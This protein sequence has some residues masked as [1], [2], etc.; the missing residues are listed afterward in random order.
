MVL[1]L[2]YFIII[3]FFCFY[4][5]GRVLIEFLKLQFS[6]LEKIIFSTIL[7]MSSFM[8]F[9]YLFSWINIPQIYLLIL[10]ILNLYFF[11]NNHNFRKIKYPRIDFLSFFII[12]FGS[13]CFSM[14]MFFS[15]FVF[16]DGIKFLVVNIADGIRHI[17]YINNQ[18]NFFPPEHPV[19]SG[20]Q[21]KGFHYF[22]DFMLAKLVEFFR[23]PVLDLYFR[24]FPFFLSLLYGSSFY[25]LAKR[26]T[27]N[28]T[29]H[30]LIVFFSYFATGFS[31]IAFLITGNFRVFNTETVHPIGLMLNPFIV[32]AITML[33]SGLAILP[34]IKKSFKY[35]I[36]LGIIY[37]VLAQI[38]VYSGIIAIEL[39]VVYSLY[40]IIRFRKRY[41]SSYFLFLILTA[42]ITAITFLPNNF[43][44]GGLIFSPFIIYRQFMETWIFLPLNWETKFRISLEAK[45]TLKIYILYFQAFIIYWI[46]NL[47]VSIVSLFG[48]KKLFK[49]SFWLDDYNF[50]LFFTIF[51]SIFM[52]TFFIQTTAVFDT[53]QFLWIVFPI[54]GI[55]A[56]LIIGNF[57]TKHKV[58]SK[59]IIAVILIFSLPRVLALEI[60]YLPQKANALATKEEVSLYTKIKSI[61]PPREFM[62]FIPKNLYIKT[63]ERKVEKFYKHGISMLPALTERSLYLEK[64]G[65]PN[66]FYDVYDKRFKNLIELEESINLCNLNK[67]KILLNEI[68]TKYILTEKD[69]PC[70]STSSS[71]LNPVVSNNLRLYILK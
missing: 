11:Y 4:I 26:I 25:L 51:C 1:T 68:G 70:F 32:F 15:G 58:L 6:Y 66:R 40:L 57:I 65:L 45:D 39:I 42:F 29:S 55:P 28:I 37:G 67:T 13:L 64:G 7:G 17:G 2:L 41:F 21:L 43:R 38:K 10:I 19:L 22:Y 27:K 23:F 71:I 24:L 12:I 47:G 18:V 5:P 3:I 9:T 54:I 48:I 14:L 16:K 69:Y 20:L 50:I 52:T 49:K 63:E 46:Y 53:V 44:Q 31:F 8:F 36:V 34:D 61:V 30:R 60:D 35:A 33:V 56:G 62:V 59:Y